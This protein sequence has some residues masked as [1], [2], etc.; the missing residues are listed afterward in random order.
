MIPFCVIDCQEMR[1]HF[2]EFFW[3]TIWNERPR[4][5]R[6]SLRKKD[7]N[8]LKMDLSKGFVREMPQKGKLTILRRGGQ[9]TQLNPW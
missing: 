2:F 6:H 4:G 9:G 5:K 7:T 8:Y 3:K 1:P